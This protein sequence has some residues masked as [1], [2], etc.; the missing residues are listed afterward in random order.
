[1][2]LKW[3]GIERWKATRRVSAIRA[4]GPTW[5]DGIAAALHARGILA[6]RG[7]AWRDVQI[8]RVLGGGWAWQRAVRKPV[9]ETLGPPVAPPLRALRAEG[10]SATP[11][12]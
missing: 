10:W 2:L 7:G 5:Q 4:A 9:T 11:R 8:H 6:P 3:F 12:R 1:M